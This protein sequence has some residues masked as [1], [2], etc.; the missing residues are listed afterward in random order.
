MRNVLFVLITLGLVACSKEVENNKAINGE[1]E[2][3]SFTFTYY[4]GIKSKPDCTGFLQFTSDGKKTKTGK[5]N[6]NAS[7]DFNGSQQSYIDNGSYSIENKNR[8]YLN[9]AVDSSETIGTV[10]YKTKEDLIFE[11]ANHNY[12]G[13][14]FVL[15]KKQ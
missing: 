7:Y 9:S 8:V 6:L 11:I 15:K 2:P 3:K 1:W 13:Y 4:D 12:L 5:Y 10:V 14:Y